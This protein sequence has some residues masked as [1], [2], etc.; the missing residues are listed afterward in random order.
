MAV[1]MQRPKLLLRSLVIL[2]TTPNLIKKTL[3]RHHLRQYQDKK[4]FK[5]LKTNSLSNNRS[6]QQMK[7]V[8][9]KMLMSHH[10]RPFL[11]IS[12]LI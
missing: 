12:K 1:K 6:F 7:L 5:L 4:K 2:T 11:D 10:R 9:L 3:L 8:P